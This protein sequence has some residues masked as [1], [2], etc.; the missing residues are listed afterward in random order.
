MAPAVGGAANV[1]G[2][3]VLA[4][5]FA[6]DRLV[7]IIVG[8]LCMGLVVTAAMIGWA[9]SMADLPT[10]DIVGLSVSGLMVYFAGSFVLFAIVNLGETSLRIRM[11]RMLLDNPGGITRADLIRS[12]DDRTLIAV[13]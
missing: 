10:A 6:G 4:R 7:M 12:Y 5:L 2:Q 3:L 13:R 9:F 11:M 1:A 8:A